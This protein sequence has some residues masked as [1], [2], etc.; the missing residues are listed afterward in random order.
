MRRR[1]RASRRAVVRRADRPIGSRATPSQ[2]G[3]EL[4][5]RV[6]ALHV[7]TFRG[8]VSARRIASTRSVRS[9]SVRSRSVSPTERELAATIL[10]ETRREVD[11]EGIESSLDVHHVRNGIIHRR[12]PLNY[13]P[14]ARSATRGQGP[15]NAFCVL[16]CAAS[17]PR[18]Q[19]HPHAQHH[20]PTR[21]SRGGEPSIPK[22]RR[23]S[24]HCQE[25][26]SNSRHVVP[27]IA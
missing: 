11:A 22:S 23:N 4:G 3:L 13:F 12:S 20:R 15:I 2:L 21:H 24:R 5:L 7:K 18:A 9:R 16:Q 8:R 27:R 25:P 10:R 6:R 26:R 1:R 19:H 14:H 17:R